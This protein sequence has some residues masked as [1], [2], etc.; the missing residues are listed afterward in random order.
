MNLRSFWL[1]LALNTSYARN[2]PSVQLLTRPLLGLLLAYP[3]L[4]LVP[5]AAIQSRTG[6][7]K[8][9]RNKSLLGIRPLEGDIN[10]I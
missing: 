5:N 3:L 6:F 2:A 8:V 7:G 9:T 1:R 10:N 4:T